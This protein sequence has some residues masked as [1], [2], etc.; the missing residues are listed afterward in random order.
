MKIIIFSI[1]FVI[2]TV[3]VFSQEYNLYYSGLD[4][5]FITIKKETNG[6]ITITPKILT[7]SVTLNNEICSLLPIS[8]SYWIY[9]LTQ[10]ITI[11]GNTTTETNS[12]GS[13]YKTVVNGNTTTWTNSDGSWYKTVV[14]G[15]TTTRTRSD[16]SWTKTVVNGNTTTWT[17]SDGSWT[18]TV[19][20]GNITTSTRSDGFWHKTVVDGN[21]T[22]ETSSNGY[23]KKT[24]I[25]KQGNDIYITTQGSG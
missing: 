15:N 21:I 2:N 25:D 10:L 11:D 22:T 17:R 13:W 7:G 8:K 12:D 19:V 23:W 4:K 14:N 5:G 24:V 18:K 1:L 6:R 9:E 16:G 20:D 3:F